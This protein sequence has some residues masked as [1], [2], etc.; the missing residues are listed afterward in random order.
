[1]GAALRQFGDNPSTWV[2]KRCDV[3]TD[4]SFDLQYVGDG[5]VTA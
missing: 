1:M 4:G 2:Y 3:S 5:R